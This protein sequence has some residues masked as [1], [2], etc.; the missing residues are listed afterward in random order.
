[1][2]IER[3]GRPPIGRVAGQRG[4]TVLEAI[5]ALALFALS[6]ATMSKF[7]VTQ[8]RTSSTNDNYTLAYELGVEELE[9]VRAQLY[10]QMESRSREHQEGGMTFEINTA[11]REGMP[12]VNMKTIDVGI[13]WHEP[14]GAR[15]VA[16]QTIY[17]AVT[18]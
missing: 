11:V 3:G 15:N 10:D 1:M 6:I 13:S 7:I 8:I 9:D 4:V 18:R 14:A 5:F 12:A 16:L 17:T 2:N